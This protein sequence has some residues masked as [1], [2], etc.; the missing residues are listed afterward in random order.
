MTQLQVHDGLLQMYPP[1]R[2]FSKK[3]GARHVIDPGIA[4]KSHQ[5]EV[6]QAN[7]VASRLNYAQHPLP[8]PVESR[9]ELR[10]E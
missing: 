8:S 7:I 1:T 4:S 5:S 3:M 9:E 6:L 2:E 10:E